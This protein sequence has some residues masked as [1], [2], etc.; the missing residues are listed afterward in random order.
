MLRFV[1]FTFCLVFFAAPQ[2][3][4]ANS[5]IDAA[6]VQKVEAYFNTLTTLKA[7]FT[8]TNSDGSVDSG[9]FYLRRPGRLRFQY[10]TN[11]DYIVADGLLI[12][13]WDDASKNYANAPIGSTLA[14]F[15]LAKKI[16][17]SGDV[18]VKKMAY[19][20]PGMTVITLVQTRDPDAGDLRLM[21]QDKPFR[22]VKWRVTDASGA[23]TEISLSLITRDMPLDPTLFRFKPPKGY[24]KGW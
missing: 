3:V 15:F 17:L 6:L 24:D 8:Q 5:A 10:A 22:L 18:T 20:R 4:R 9:V 19:P 12:H 1:L 11:K 21:F 23:V 16:R 14:D 7:R 13:Y 2:H